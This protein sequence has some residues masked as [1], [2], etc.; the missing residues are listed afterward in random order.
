[1]SDRIV[2]P[3]AYVYDARP[4]PIRP[5][6]VAENERVR[7]RLASRDAGEAARRWRPDPRQAAPDRHGL[8]RQGAAPPLPAPGREPAAERSPLLSFGLSSA[9]YVTQ[10]LAQD[11]RPASNDAD[12]RLHADGAA[13]YRAAMARGATILGPEYP[14][15]LS[16]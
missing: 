3:A 8:E 5:E 13:A 11:A 9:P 10:A 16:A 15:S 6:P 2:F 4:P 1:M 12:R 14:I 7:L